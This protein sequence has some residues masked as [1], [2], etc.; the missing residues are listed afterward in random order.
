MF[1]QVYLIKI[2]KNK[3]KNRGQFLLQIKISWSMF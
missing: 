3:N 2:Y 1:G